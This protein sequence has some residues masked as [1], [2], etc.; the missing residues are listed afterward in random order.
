[1]GLTSF[2]SLDQ[3]DFSITGESFISESVEEFFDEEFHIGR[4]F[5]A[6]RDNISHL[7][8]KR[9]HILDFISILSIESFF[10]QRSH[11]LHDTLTLGKDRSR[12]GR[13]IGSDIPII[14]LIFLIGFFEE[15]TYQQFIRKRQFRI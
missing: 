2:Q 4:R 3:F 12:K 14:V 10:F 13:C 7:V 1:M 11:L 6:L 5:L 8:G 9:F 15:F